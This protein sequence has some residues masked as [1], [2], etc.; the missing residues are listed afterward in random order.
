MMVQKIP[1]EGLSE[2]LMI[3]CLVNKKDRALL[4]D[5]RQC[6][7]TSTVGQ[8]FQ[9]LSVLVGDAATSQTCYSHDMR[10]R[11]SAERVVSS[12]EQLSAVRTGV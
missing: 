7:S 3:N 5:F 2:P 1:W 11:P 9:L 10:N 8:D 12:L 4:S 6:R